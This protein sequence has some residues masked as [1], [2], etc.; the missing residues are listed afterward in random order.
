M[1]EVRDR[2]Q[3]APAAAPAEF[4]ISLQNRGVLAQPGTLLALAERAEALGYDAP[5]G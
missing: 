1:A 4:S 5:S 2:R 3:P